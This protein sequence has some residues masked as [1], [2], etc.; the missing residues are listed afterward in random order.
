[1]TKISAFQNIYVVYV[2]FFYCSFDLIV[3]ACLY[4]KAS[5]LAAFWIQPTMACIIFRKRLITKVCMYLK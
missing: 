4:V 2:V 1:M 5:R 3:N